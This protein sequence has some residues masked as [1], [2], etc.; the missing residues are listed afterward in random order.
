MMPVN[1]KQLNRNSEALFGSARVAEAFNRQAEAN[2]LHE[3][4]L[5]VA[6]G[7]AGISAGETVER[8]WYVLCVGNHS[9][10]A[11]HNLLSA[12]AVEAFV[13]MKMTDPQRRGSRPVASRIA[14]SVPAFPGYVFARIVP[15]AEAWQGIL[16]LD[17]VV[18][19]IGTAEHPMPVSD[20]EINKLIAFVNAGG[21]DET[22][23]ADKLRKG[24]RVLIKDGPFA[25]FEA[26]VTGYAGTKHVRVLTALFGQQTTVKLTLAQIVKLG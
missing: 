15:C 2:R 6:A 25:Y 24:D 13:P 4:H 20:N 5:A 7:A 3:W 11:V 19:V 10:I 22:V 23:E 21:L 17:G 1:H 14:K 26:T 16:R 8:R 12:H 9:E 18:G